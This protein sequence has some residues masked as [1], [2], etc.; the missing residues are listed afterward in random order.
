MSQEATVEEVI[1]SR[2]F[3]FSGFGLLYCTRWPGKIHIFQYTIQMHRFKMKW[4]SPECLEGPEIQIQ[5]QKA[6]EQ[7]MDLVELSVWF[8]WFV[9]VIWLSWASC[10]STVS[11]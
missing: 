5:L 9:G 1:K 2:T 8:G 11:N 7:T 6:A 3:S 4:L 10:I